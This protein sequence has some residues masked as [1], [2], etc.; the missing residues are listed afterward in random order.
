MLE[1]IQPPYLFVVLAVS[2][3]LRKNLYITLYNIENDNTGDDVSFLLQFG[4]STD[5]WCSAH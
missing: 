5:H 3:Y 4:S 2:H 1:E